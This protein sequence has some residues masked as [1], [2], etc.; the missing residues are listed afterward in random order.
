M[1]PSWQVILNCTSYGMLLLSEGGAEMTALGVQLRDW[2]KKCTGRA[3][4]PHEVCLL[5]RHI[6]E[7][8]DGLI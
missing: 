8:V 7:R 4:A 6:S 2:L 1:V 5:M 3:V